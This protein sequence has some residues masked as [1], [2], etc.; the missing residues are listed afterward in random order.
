MNESTYFYTTD[1]NFADI[2]CKNKKPTLKHRPA[3]WENMLGTV[4]AMNDEGEVKYFDYDWDAAK[5]FAG[6]HWKRDPRVFKNGYRKGW[7]DYRHTRHARFE[8]QVLFILREV[9]E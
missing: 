8:Q 4:Y 2:K 9:P 5:E 1:A 7:S 3:L 6:I